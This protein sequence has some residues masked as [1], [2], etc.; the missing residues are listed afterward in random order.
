[1]AI[2]IGKKKLS[3]RSGL[4]LTSIGTSHGENTPKGVQISDF[5]D[6]VR[7]RA[8]RYV[9]CTMKGIEALEREYQL[10]TMP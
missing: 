9:T 4:K 5:N 1:M 8:P 10:I 6:L 3:T 2:E 7:V